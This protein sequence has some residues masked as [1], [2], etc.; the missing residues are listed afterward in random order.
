MVLAVTGASPA[1]AQEDDAA[2]P[3][4]AP[5]R[6]Q[7]QV[8][9]VRLLRSKWV[10]AM[11]YED[12]VW[13]IA[14]Q[15]GRRLIH[16]PLILQAADE[17]YDI[18]GNVIELRGGRFLA[19][20][21]QPDPLIAQGEATPTPVTDA[22]PPT[23]PLA[24]RRL[25]VEPGGLLSR[26]QLSWKLD[27]FIAGGT[28]KE[29][30]LDYVL[31]V[32]PRQFEKLDPGRAAPITRDGN[33]DMRAFQTRKRQ[34]EVDHMNRQRAFRE[35]RD[36]VNRLPDTFTVPMPEVVWAMYEISDFGDDLTIGGVAEQRWTTQISTVQT[37]RDL[38][39]MSREEVA[40]LPA[41]RRME[42][43]QRLQ[44]M[45]SSK[46]PLSER[47][48]AYAVNDADL[49][50]LA[51]SPSDDVAV[52]LRT[53]LTAQDREA[54]LVAL[55][56]ISS[57]VP[58]TRVTLGLIR[59][60]AGQFDPTM[61]L[62]SLR[63]LL[64]A[65]V[66]EPQQLQALIASTNQILASAD[67]PPPAEVLD[68]VLQTVKPDTL[69]AM[70]AGVDFDAMPDARR[71]EAI[72]LVIV[73][74]P[75]HELAQ[76]WLSL[77]LLASQR[78]PVVRQT[79]EQLA[80]AAPPAAATPDSIFGEPT[81]SAGTP[82]NV[83]GRVMGNIFGGDRHDHDPPQS[84]APAKTS[85]DNGKLRLSAPIPL[86]STQHG[87]F[88]AL[89]NSD[90]AIRRLAWQALPCFALP[91]Q[92]P[93][94]A[95]GGYDPATDPYALLV[96]NARAQPTVPDTLVPFMLRHQD[97]R[98]VTWALCQVLL[99][100]DAT[101]S[102]QAAA[103]LLGSKLPLQEPLQAMSLGDRHK[104]AL[105]MYQGV[106]KVQPLVAGLMRWNNPANPLIPWFAT[107]VSEGELPPPQRWHEQI[108]N[109]DQR[110]LIAL[111]TDRELALAGAAALASSVGGGDEQARDVAKRFELI[112][113]RNADG[114]RPEWQL[115]RRQ[116]LADRVRAAAG[117][118]DMKLKLHAP[119][120]PAAPPPDPNAPLG[121]PVEV[122][123]LG[124]VALVIEGEGLVMAS[125]T[126]AIS[127]PPDQ[128]VIR[129]EKLAELKNF[130]G[131]RVQGLPLDQVE[132][133]LDLTSEGDRQWQGVFTMPDGAKAKLTLEPP[134]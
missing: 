112:T 20:H 52:L 97:T 28:V 22:L 31:K 107:Q 58:P 130:P 73:E 108:D 4:A 61:Q 113:T 27:R 48:A 13:T 88:V 75:E 25:T 23:A 59:E 134:G 76:R 9:L 111:S 70:T 49:A 16:V 96:A 81:P 56:E 94:P 14:P 68:A 34:L 12:D 77:K 19:F 82:R 5:P 6:A 21:L 119:P 45:A 60:F 26:G 101:A 99:N 98:R 67:G 11:P 42:V 43:M 78:A 33:E 44:A 128:F 114:A 133:T 17:P 120:D 84:D 123:D 89:A 18:A 91:Q 118:Y 106:D 47:L 103:A 105:R 29:V 80:D 57:T 90:E 115:L 65:E 40:S 8:D 54:K 38:V 92:M 71:V 3:V 102:A 85:A 15:P 124:A 39:A 125:K 51:G 2:E 95:A 74:A 63:G 55:T 37:L 122:I 30:D 117:D 36:T 7:V 64:A 66:T 24:T 1:W 129:I 100:D 46:H 83:V 10:F 86:D 79:V 53:L 69:D 127:S 110:L 116:I 121:E 109:D 72:R 62:V 35:R 41:V 132:Q 32:D 126:L 87:Y 131:E 93:E 104:F 50:R